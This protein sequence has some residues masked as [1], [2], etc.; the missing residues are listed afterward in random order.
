MTEGR[1]ASKGRK[2]VSRKRRK[3]GD[4]KEERGVQEDVMKKS[5]LEGRTRKGDDF[6]N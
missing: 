3:E 1:P 5:E 4:K 6:L 2:R